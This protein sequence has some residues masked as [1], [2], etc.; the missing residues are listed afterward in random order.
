MKYH[1]FKKRQV[2][3][4]VAFVGSAWQGGDIA[5]LPPLAVT[6]IAWYATAR[7]LD[8]IAEAGPR[9]RRGSRGGRRAAAPS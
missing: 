4:E 9:R 6:R 7:A 3:F 8:H 2:W 1:F 5:P